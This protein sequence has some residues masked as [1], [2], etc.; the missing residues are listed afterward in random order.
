MDE[1]QILHTRPTKCT[2][3]WADGSPCH[4]RATVGP[5]PFVALT[6]PVAH[7]RNACSREK[8]LLQTFGNNITPQGATV[9]G[10]CD[11]NQSDSSTQRPWTAP[12]YRIRLS[13]WHLPLCPTSRAVVPGV[14]CRCARPPVR[15]HPPPHAIRACTFC[16]SL[17]IRKLSSMYPTMRTNF[18]HGI[19][20][21]STSSGTHG[22]AETS[23]IPSTARGRSES[24]SW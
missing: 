5:G 8:K 20:S 6:R 13:A 24:S 16:Q 21:V 12:P 1:R 10:T 17:A 18:G 7:P 19:E 3:T 14:R 4:S 11:A 2:V 15:A 9:P 23:N 22:R